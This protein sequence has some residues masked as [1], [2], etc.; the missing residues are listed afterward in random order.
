MAGQWKLPLSASQAK[1]RNFYFGSSSATPWC[2]DLS[3]RN[4][5][6]VEN[7]IAMAHRKVSV[8]DK[9]STIFFAQRCAAVP[10]APHRLTAFAGCAA[11]ALG[12]AL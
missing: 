3:H 11:D 2:N 5:L 7:R 4:H 9:V 6:K 8:E 1:S 10:L 12:N